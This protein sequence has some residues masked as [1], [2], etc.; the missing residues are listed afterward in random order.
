MTRAVR[1]A[2]LLAFAFAFDAAAIGCNVS[3]VSLAFG[4]YDPFRSAHTDSSALITVTCLGRRGQMFAYNISLDEGKS[5]AFA[6]RRMRAPVGTTLNYNLY[7]TSSR[8]VIWGDGNSGTSIVADSVKLSS[9][10][11][12]ATRQY[13]VHGRVFARQNARVGVY[14]DTIVVTLN[15]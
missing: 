14:T 8:S 5:G 11:A 13:P 6:T 7:V 2:A 3:A 15:F 9:S 1:A 10:H 4:A 12:Q